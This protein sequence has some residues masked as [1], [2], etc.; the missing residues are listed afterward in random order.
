MN[1]QRL[2]IDLHRLDLRFAAT[3]VVEPR[4][5]AAIARSIEQSGQ[6]VPCVVVADATG[7]ALV[8]VDGY[9]RVAALRQLG[10]DIA[11]VER[12]PCDLVAALVGVLARATGRSF[13][14]IEEALLIRDLIE[15]QGLSQREMASRC[16]RDV[17]WVNRRLQLLAALPETAVAAVRAGQ[18]SAW[19][20]NRVIAPLARANTDHAERLLVAL[21]DAP[22]PT[23]D[24][25]GWFE[26]YEKASQ[27]VRERM[28]DQPRLFLDARRDTEARRAGERLRAGPE[29]D[30]AADV[31]CL[32]AVIARLRKRLKTLPSV[33]DVV[34]SAVPRL[35]A[36][37]D[38]LTAEIE[39]RSSDHDPNRN[40][41][42]S[43]KP[44][45]KRPQPARDQPDAG[46]VP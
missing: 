16:G 17:S 33:P 20:A 38:A 3:R 42:G 1:T 5:V 43:A 44:G 26:H 19:A 28:V 21:R 4:A 35:R 25:R 6:I 30:C 46:A 40:P 27:T 7:D 24:L 11:S 8:L 14:A 41:H 22:V 37:V 31:R 13:A 15:G 34:L 23:R 2:D 18:L 10:R 32:E 36:A 9:R 29:G 39:K 12:W 45:G